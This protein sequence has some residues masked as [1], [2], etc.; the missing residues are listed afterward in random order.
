MQGTLSEQA[1]AAS[2][3]PLLALSNKVAD[4][5]RYATMQGYDAVLMPNQFG[6]DYF[7]VGGWAFKMRDVYTPQEGDRI[8]V[9]SL[10]LDISVEGNDTGLV[11]ALR[12]LSSGTNRDEPARV[13]SRMLSDGAS[14]RFLEQGRIKLPRYWGRVVGLEIE[15]VSRDQRVRVRGFDVGLVEG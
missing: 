15:G 6:G 13:F 9:E 7:V 8:A 14:D 3:R 10:N 11:L 4:V 5:G 1:F 2:D 12:I